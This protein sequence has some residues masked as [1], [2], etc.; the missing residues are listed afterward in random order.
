MSECG[1]KCDCPEAKA[2]RKCPQSCGKDW[3]ECGCPT[4]EEKQRVLDRSEGKTPARLGG[5][6]LEMMERLA[7]CPGAGK[8]ES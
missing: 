8:G 2:Q 6:M 5:S 3:P 1:P 4:A 7:R